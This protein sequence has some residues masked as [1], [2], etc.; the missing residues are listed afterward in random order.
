MREWSLHRHVH[1]DGAGSISTGMVAPSGVGAESEEGAARDVARSWPSTYGLDR[2]RRPAERLGAERWKASRRR[3]EDVIPRR[4]LMRGE[5][6]SRG[7]CPSRRA[8]RTEMGGFSLLTR[9]RLS[10][11]RWKGQGRV[12]HAGSWCSS[13]HR[14]DEAALT[15]RRSVLYHWVVTCPPHECSGMQILDI[16]EPSGAGR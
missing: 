9:S 11:V 2:E 10:A 13:H 12:A 8:A 14:T 5:L 4:R 6:S 15:G 16:R 3:P 1:G 7:E